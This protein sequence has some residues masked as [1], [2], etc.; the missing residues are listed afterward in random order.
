MLVNTNLLENTM[1][2]L[3]IRRPSIFLKEM[4]IYKKTSDYEERKGGVSLQKVKKNALCRTFHL[5]TTSEAE[6]FHFTKWS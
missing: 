3:L 6:A 5:G 4:A 1:T 2:T